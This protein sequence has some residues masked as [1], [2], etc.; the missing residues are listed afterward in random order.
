LNELEGGKE[1]D[2]R[3][4]CILS[5]H[6]LISNMDIDSPSAKTADSEDEHDD[7]ED[8]YN[9]HTELFELEPLREDS[10]DEDDIND[11]DEEDDDD[12]DN[13]DNNDNDN[14]NEQESQSSSEEEEEEEQVHGLTGNEREILTL[15]AVDKVWTC[16]SNSE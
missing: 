11:D 2:I 10:E 6:Q 1:G 9:P 5:L 4:E 15:L 16:S 3:I 8:G 7:F 12:N 13:D 14:D